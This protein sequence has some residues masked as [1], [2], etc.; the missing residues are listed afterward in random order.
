MELQPEFSAVV[1]E[2]N[3]TLSPREKWITLHGIETVPPHEV[4][5][6]GLRVMI[7]W[8]AFIPGGKSAVGATRPDAISTLAREIG[9]DGWENFNWEG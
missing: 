1:E 8:V 4:S 5:A 7:G 6:K 2:A 9:L 3:E